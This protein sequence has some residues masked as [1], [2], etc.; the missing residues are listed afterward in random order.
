MFKSK[1]VTKWCNSDKYTKLG[2][3]MPKVYTI[4]F[5]GGDKQVQI[6]SAGFTNDNQEYSAGPS[7]V[8]DEYG[9]VYES[10]VE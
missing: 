8:V 10:N 3:K 4:K 6:M 5:F 7:N 1:H 2:Y 9:Y